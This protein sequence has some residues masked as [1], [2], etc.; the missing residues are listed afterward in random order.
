MFEDGRFFTGD[1]RATF[2]SA[3]PVDPGEVPCEEYS[4]R[5]LTGRGSSSQW[6]TLTRTGKSA[7][8]GMLSTNDAYVEI[9]P[10]DAERLGELD[11]LP[12]EGD[13]TLGGV[14]PFTVA[15]GRNLG[16]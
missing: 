2:H 9:H 6:H 10:A 8:L 16:R 7:V 11:P 13:P 3:D 12:V 1:E 4:F 14:A 15:D 5:L